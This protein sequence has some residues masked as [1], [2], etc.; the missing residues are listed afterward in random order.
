MANRKYFHITSKGE[1]KQITADQWLH[2]AQ[3]RNLRKTRKVASVYNGEITLYKGNNYMFIRKREI[4]HI[5]E[6][7]AKP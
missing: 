3:E 7:G 5:I 4:Q 2:I 1:V 6:E